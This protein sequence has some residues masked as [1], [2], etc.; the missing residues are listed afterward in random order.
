LNLAAGSELPCQW[1]INTTPAGVYGSD[2]AHLYR[3]A[4]ME[5]I[6]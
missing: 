4:G 5:D 6:V 3:M 2:V 1:S